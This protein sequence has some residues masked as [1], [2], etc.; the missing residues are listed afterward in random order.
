MDGGMPGKDR[1]IRGFDEHIELQIRTPIVE[2]L[3]EGQAEDGVSQG[4]QSNEENLR[5]DGQL[6]TNRD[7]IRRPGSREYWS[8]GFR[9]WRSSLPASLLDRIGSEKPTQARSWLHPRA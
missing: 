9:Q 7:K 6:G 5:G 8:S 1:G 4:S 3:D 2:G